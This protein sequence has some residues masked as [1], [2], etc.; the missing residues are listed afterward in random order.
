MATKEQLQTDIADL[1]VAQKKLRAGERVG[2]VMYQGRKTSFVE[3]SLPQLA[4][5]EAR[6]NRQLARKTNKRYSL[7]STGKGF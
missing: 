5:E 4:E 3:V 7:I 2:E 6:L 1:R